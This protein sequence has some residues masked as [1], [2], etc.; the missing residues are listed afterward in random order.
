MSWFHLRLYTEVFNKMAPNVL[1]IISFFIVLS[2]IFIHVMA[3]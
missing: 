1:A 2:A 3:F